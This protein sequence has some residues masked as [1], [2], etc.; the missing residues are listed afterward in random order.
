M[1]G[2]PVPR[3]ASRL[4]LSTGV[5]Y[6]K[7]VGPKLAE[8]LAARGIFTVEDLLCTLPFRYEDRSHHRPIQQLLE[9]ETA[10]VVAQIR[11]LSMPRSR[12]GLQLLR[13]T[14][15]DGSGTLSCLWF[16]AEFLRDRFQSGQ[17]LAL[18]GRIE[19]EG[20]RLLLRQPEFE[21]LE[22]G[23]QAGAEVADSLKIGRIVPIYEA[24]A[25]L[26]S[27]RL[28]RLMHRS[29]LD[30][31]VA[32]PD[33]IPLELRQRLHL[34][35]RHTALQQV[36][37]PGPETP[38]DLL[39]QARSP[40]HIRLILEEL[41]FLQAGL[42]LKRRRARRQ[43]GPRMDVTPAVRERLK[44]IL[45][46]HP[47]GDQK[48]VLREIAADLARGH[49]MRRL[50]QGDVASGKTIVALQAAV[51]AIENGYQAAIMAPTQILAEQHYLYARLRL[52]G[53]RIELVA[54]GLPRRAST[55]PRAQLLIG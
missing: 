38:L 35:D 10:T 1:A 42:E 36:H 27:G 9:G 34:P 28:R 6:V 37:F 16:H 50:L 18:Y 33:P 3:L 25:E 12:G 15:G 24:I 19:R 7:G 40:G 32:I 30:L 17:T 55:T 51:I 13:M 29:L 8:L 45:P 22:T 4:S 48:A 53:Y 31:P 5:Q 2:S 49:P 11:T 54:S 41:F 44:Q 39:Q 14:V 26:A 47:T 21:I 23:N 20:G 52:S 46:F 43:A